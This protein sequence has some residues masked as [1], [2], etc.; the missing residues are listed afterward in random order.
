MLLQCSAAG[1]VGQP[2]LAADAILQLPPQHIQ[3]A[4]E[5]PGVRLER[6]TLTRQRQLQYRLPLRKTCVK[7]GK[8]STTAGLRCGLECCQCTEQQQML[9]PT[10]TSA[11]DAK[12][13]F[14]RLAVQKQ[15][16][17]QLKLRQQ[18]VSVPTDPLNGIIQQRRLV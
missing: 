9:A 15:H 11:G 7:A 3:Q 6:G 2:H 14:Q 1:T 17:G 16:K 4:L 10:R 18:L 12:T 8:P 13:T 5:E